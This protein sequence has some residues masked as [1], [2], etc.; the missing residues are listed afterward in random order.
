MKT[1]EKFRLPDDLDGSE[2]MKDRELK[3]GS[4]ELDS[5]GEKY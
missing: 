5:D 3:S 1:P 4:N 2:D